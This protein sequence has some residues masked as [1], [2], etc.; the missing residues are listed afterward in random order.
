MWIY[1]GV[2]MG[3]FMIYWICSLIF[4]YYF[5]INIIEGIKKSFINDYL[6][7]FSCWNE[8]FYSFCG[9]RIYLFMVYI[10]VK[11]LV[12]KKMIC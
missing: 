12:G 3:N 7:C 4:I 11:I 5:I 2:T 9:S 6:V 8:V 10:I 1:K